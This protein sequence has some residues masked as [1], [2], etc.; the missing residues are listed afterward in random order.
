[1]RVLLWTD[2]A[3][4]GI[5]GGHRVQADRTVEAL[6]RLGVEVELAIGPEASLDGVDVVHSFG[7]DRRWLRAAREAR[8]PVVVSTIY[9][10]QRY[11]LGMDKRV[12]LA[13][14]LRLA[15]SV[16]RR[17][18]HET[19]M[20]VARPVLDKQL[21][22]EFADLLLPNS[23]SEAATI[24]DELDV[25]TPTWVVPNGVDHRV[26]TPPADGA[27]RD[28][29]L[30]VGR[31]EP[32]KNQLGLIRALDGSGIPLS[33]VGR[34]H[35]DH[36]A[37]MAACQKAA[38]ANVRFLGRRTDAELVADYQRAAVHAMPSW[39]E[40][41]GLSS[42]EAAA[43]GAAVVTTN[44][45]FVRDY[46]DDLAYYCDP[47]DPGSV[48]DAVQAALANGPSAELRRRVLD[49]FTWDHAGEATLAAYEKAIAMVRGSE[50]IP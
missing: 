23:E 16:M 21:A 30:Y 38:G 13:R 45:G 25:T 49:R 47:D 24:R 32:H 31:I 40:T 46:F 4:D 42:L 33:F 17:G 8:I 35:P 26:F 48:L 36:G 44:R 39:Y 20:T 50:T 43:C 5:P 34:V 6:Q 14:R 3:Y 19:A 9:W 29:V 18:A 1:M 41:T 22:F 12:G 28:G 27:T 15:S 11:V 10:S 7:A 2:Q 37:Y